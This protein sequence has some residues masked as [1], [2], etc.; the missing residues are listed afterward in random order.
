MSS[1][2]VP[3]RSV[4][5]ADRAPAGLAALALTLGAAFILVPRVLASSSSSDA[6]LEKGDLIGAVRGAFV[7]YWASGDISLPLALDSVVDY[8]F[9]YHVVKAVIA[10][11]LLVVLYA[12]GIFL[13]KAFLRATGF[14]LGRRVA[15]ASASGFVSVL[16]LFSLLIVMANIQGAVAPFASLLPMLTGGQVDAELAVTLDQVRQR[17]AEVPSGAHQDPPALAVMIGGFAQYHVVLAVLA[18]IVAVGF[19]GISVMV[20]RGFA[21]AGSTDRRAK[22]LLG[23]FGVLAVSFLLVVVVLAVANATTAADPAPALLA[24]FEGGW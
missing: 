19:V 10:A 16:A 24:F 4:G 2:A 14:G 23:S 21:R 20:W 7:E 22:R 15:L 5:I 12:L 8:W 6:L 3:S 11:C 9:R 17:L 13:C 1:H 18:A